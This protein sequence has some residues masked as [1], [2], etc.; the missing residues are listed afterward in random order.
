M[1]A[2]G[3]PR[4]GKSCFETNVVCQD[5]EQ[6]KLETNKGPR[7]NGGHVAM[8]EE[9]AQARAKSTNGRLNFKVPMP[10]GCA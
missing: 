2:T 8:C 3:P 5:T 9:A 7:G 6:P 10:T 4:C 1:L